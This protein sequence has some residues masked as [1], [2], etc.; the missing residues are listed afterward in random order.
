MSSAR[1][2]AESFLS[3]LEIPLLIRLGASLVAGFLIGAE[4]ESRGK[5]AGISTHS[6]VI[7]G[8]AV[9][10]MLSMVLGQGDPGRIAAQIVTGVGFLG[11]G[12]I[13]KRDDGGVQNLTTAASIWFSAAIGM[14]IGF[15]LYAIAAA[16]TIFSVVVPRIPHISK[17][18]QDR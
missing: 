6:F 16:A 13:L 8:A 15:G 18:H 2:A 4:R 11:A 3:D 14:S 1:L 7:G 10:A 12:I 5:P 17:R 9:F